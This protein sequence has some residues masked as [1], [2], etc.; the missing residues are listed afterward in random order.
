LSV[1]VTAQMTA[2]RLELEVD[3]CGWCLY[4]AGRAICTGLVWRGLVTQLTPAVGLSNTIDVLLE[5][6]TEADSATD[7][8]N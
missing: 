4:Y 8:R 1:S 6:S 3:L 7:G 5:S 2:F